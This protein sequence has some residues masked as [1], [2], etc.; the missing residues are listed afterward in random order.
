MRCSARAP[1]TTASRLLGDH[2]T[3]S[4]A[5]GGKRI[6]VDLLE[7]YPYTQVYAPL[8]H[9]YLAFEPMTAPANALISGDGLRIVAAGD[10][11]SAKFRF[12]VE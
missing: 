10:T 7:G 9:D 8:G 1:S 6:S 2:A 11:F 5:A 12:R 3:L 4:V